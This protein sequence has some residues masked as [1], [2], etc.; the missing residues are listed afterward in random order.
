MG[1]V[2]LGCCARA[3]TCRLHASVASCARVVRSFSV[4]PRSEA[5]AQETMVRLDYKRFNR[6][7]CRLS[8]LC[9]SGIKPSLHTYCTFTL[10]YSCLPFLTHACL[11]SLGTAH[12]KFT[13]EHT[14][15]APHLSA[16]HHFPL[17]HDSHLPTFSSSNTISDS[18]LASECSL[19]AT[20]RHSL[21]Q[22]YDD[23]VGINPISFNVSIIYFRKRFV[24]RYG[25]SWSC[26]GGWRLST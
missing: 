21:R 25:D 24:D 17:R 1:N 22:M 8:E 14:P 16:P 23:S 2:C 15:S 11:R 7:T 9:A 12:S 10:T 20:P 19:S 6:S 13:H 26:G 4:G 5:R 18:I 3:F